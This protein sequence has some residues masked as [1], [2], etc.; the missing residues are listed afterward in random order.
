MINH[1]EVV[2][3]PEVTQEVITRDFMAPAKEVVYQPVKEVKII[4]NN[5]R[6]ELIPGEDTF[7]T[8]NTV[9]RDAVVRNFET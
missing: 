6:V 9:Q 1:P 8:L 5:E 2:R 7:E 4:T 3:D